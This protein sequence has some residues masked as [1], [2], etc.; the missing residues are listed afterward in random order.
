MP[1]DHGVRLMK[2]IVDEASINNSSTDMHVE[3]ECGKRLVVIPQAIDPMA[4]E[5]KIFNRGSKLALT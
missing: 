2:E 5:H 1:L 4:V 3:T